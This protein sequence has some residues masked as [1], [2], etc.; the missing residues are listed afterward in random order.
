MAIPDRDVR[1]LDADGN[2]I[3]A[4]F[5]FLVDT[6]LPAAAALADGFANP[7]VPMVGACL[8][9]FN[10]TTWDRVRGNQQAVTILGGDA[11]TVTTTSGNFVNYTGRGVVITLNV[12]IASGTGGLQLLI[13]TIGGTSGTFGQIN[14]TPPAILA[15]GLYWYAI[16]PGASG[17]GG[18]RVQ[19]LTNFVLANTYRVTVQHVNATSY[20]YSVSSNLVA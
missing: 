12:T 2:P 20:T 18:A 13:E 8:H 5:P 4:G 19:Q 17:S 9:V 14:A 3:G 15:T 16:Y 11:R 10:G 6:E 7:T 1:I